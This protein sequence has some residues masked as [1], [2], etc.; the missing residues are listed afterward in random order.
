[1]TEQENMIDCYQQSLQE[2]IDLSIDY[3]GFNSS[4]D[5]KELIDELVNIAKEGLKLN[6]PQYIVKGNK[7]I[8]HVRDTFSS[9]FFTYSSNEVKEENWSKESK[10]FIDTMK[11]IENKKKDK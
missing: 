3:D 4:E 8:E 2:I 7:V 5:L 6:R 11:I 10:E 1:M 9:A